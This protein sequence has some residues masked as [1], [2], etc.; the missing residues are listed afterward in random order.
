MTVLTNLGEVVMFKTDDK[1]IQIS[2]AVSY[3]ILALYGII[4][5]F[6]PDYIISQYSSLV[7]NDTNRFFLGWYGMMNFGAVAGL[8]YMGYK[9]LDR[10]YFTYAIPLSILFII[11]TY[12]GQASLPEAE[13]NW[14]AM[15][16]FVINALALIIARVRG[17]GAI[18]FTKA[19]N[20]WGTSDKLCQAILWLGLIG[21]VF[22]VL[23]YIFAPGSFI[24]QTPGLEAS[25]VAQRFVMGLMFFSLAWTIALLYQLRTGYSM[26]LIV[27]S[28]V[29][30]T[31]F[32]CTMLNFYASGNVQDGGNTL[33]TVNII[34]NFVG[35]LILFFRLQS[36]H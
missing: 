6:N 30:S 4:N 20:M 15:G 12:L 24:A 23:Q 14:T 31:M 5:Y 8:I 19:D 28:V 9:G 7:S 10:A 36:Q 29:I 22:F 2:L 26:S 27:T 35:S 17:L 34:G 25:E 1:L 3:A 18:D 13:Q 32:M 33:L 21:Q 11:W 16:L